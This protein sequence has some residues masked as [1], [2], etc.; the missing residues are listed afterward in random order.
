MAD[1]SGVAGGFTCRSPAICD[2]YLATSCPNCETPRRASHHPVQLPLYTATA[3][4]IRVRPERNEWRF[5][6]ME[7]DLDGHGLDNQPGQF[8]RLV[9]NG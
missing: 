3:S 1:E 4:L 2:T 7:G 8:P 6:R 5:Y 9:L